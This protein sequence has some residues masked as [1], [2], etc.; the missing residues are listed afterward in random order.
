MAH[1]KITVLSFI[2]ICCP[3]L[4]LQAGVLSKS[5]AAEIEKSRDP[6][7][8]SVSSTF[9]FSATEIAA[10]RKSGFS[11]DFSLVMLSISQKAGVSIGT[12]ISLRKNK[13]YSWKDMCDE[14]GIDYY[15]LMD[16]LEKKLIDN[17][18]VPPPS[19]SDERKQN[20]ASNRR[21]KDGGKK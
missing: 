6:Y 7:Y 21:L 17:K 1:K 18:I 3:A 4:I 12:L 8:S 20:A 13:G 2:L 11:P 16:G 5:S 19:T 10:A 15:S 9:K 14:Y